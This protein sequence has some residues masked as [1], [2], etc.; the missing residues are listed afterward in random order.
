MRQVCARCE[1]AAGHNM[2]NR[3]FVINFG[4]TTAVVS[5]DGGSEVLCC[6]SRAPPYE[7]EV[8]PCEEGADA[9]ISTRHLRDET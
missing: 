3:K 5:V 4:I 9:C 2:R 7:F 1:A 8:A 6:S